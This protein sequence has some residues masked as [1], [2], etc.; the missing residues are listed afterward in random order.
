MALRLLTVPRSASPIQWCRWCASFFSRRTGPPESLHRTSGVP[1]L[2]KSPMTTPRVA[3]P[4][5]VPCIRSHSRLHGAV[6]AVTHPRC[7]RD[8]RKAAAAP[9]VKERV[10]GLVVGD[11]EVGPAV[12][13]QVGAHHAQTRAPGIVNA[14]LFRPF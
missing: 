9:I 11:E 5:H 1:L 7:Q 12:V 4:I 10:R 8:I 6:L 14:G 13:V 3:V 2:S